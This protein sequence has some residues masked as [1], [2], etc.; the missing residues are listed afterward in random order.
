MILSIA[1]LVRWQAYQYHC[2]YVYT[3]G[4]SQSV[5]S[6][7]FTKGKPVLFC[8]FP[9]CVYAARSKGSCYAFHT[10]HTTLHRWCPGKWFI[11]K[12]LTLKHNPIICLWQWDKN[13][14][15]LLLQSFCL[16]SVVF[17]SHG[18]DVKE[19]HNRQW[20]TQLENFVSYQP[21]K[22]FGGLEIF[23]HLTFIIL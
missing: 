12:S 1:D 20:P 16:V 9:T 11:Y 22:N 15:F 6:G 13:P 7:I 18:Q 3:S 23:K 4:L 17:F 8:S 21:H 14:I 19:V 2:V 10:Q 5:V